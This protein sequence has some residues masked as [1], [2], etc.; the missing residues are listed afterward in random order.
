VSAG[1]TVPEGELDRLL[2]SWAATSRLTATEAE[3]VRLAVVGSR[4]PGLDAAW[5]R[6]LV[7]QVSA[8]VIDAARLPESSR[9]ALRGSWVGLT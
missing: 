8:V 6:D 4:T 7:G 2:E 9:S 1:R 3:Q 5:W